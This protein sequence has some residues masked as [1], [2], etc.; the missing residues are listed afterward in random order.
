MKRSAYWDS[1]KFILIS[2]V[3]YTHTISPFRVDSQFNTAIY[4]FVYL[5]HMPLFVFIS[6]RFSHINEKKRFINRT[7]KLV[8]TYIVFQLLFIALSYV[9]DNSVS[10]SSFTKPFWIFWYLLSLAYWRM[11]V[12]FMP[13]KWLLHRKTILI[14][15]LCLS[16][17][18]GYIPIGYHFSIHR[19]LSFLPFFVMGSYSANIDILKYMKR[20]PLFIAI[21]TLFVIFIIY[22]YLMID[23]YS[24]VLHC[25]YM[26]WENL[27]VFNEIASPVVRCI[28]IVLAV[29]ISFMVLR[30]VSARK[31]LADCGVKTLFIYVYHSLALK[32]L[33]QFISRGYLPK[34]EILLV[35]YSILIIIGLLFL[36]R[37]KVFYMLLNPIS[38]FCES[39]LNNKIK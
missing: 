25:P 27:L 5:F 38:Y 37:F 8:E 2:L 10:I 14:L 24:F 28:F 39:R 22:F 26:D 15:S 11:M 9:L 18:A 17:V 29:F 3:V 12:Y 21:G 16:L 33:F 13:D 32:L 6:G 1:L 7:L 31:I 23:N 20:I 19:T 35:V 34:N 36:S 30:L 4:N